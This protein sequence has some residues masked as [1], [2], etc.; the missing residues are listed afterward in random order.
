MGFE[1]RIA[2]IMRNTGPARFFVPLGIILIVFGIIVM[3]FNTDDYTL[4]MGTIT[5]V[6]ESVTQEGQKEYDVRFTY[7]ADGKTYEGTFA[8]LPGDFSVGNGIKVYYDPQD[9][10]K[11]T[12]SKLGFLPPI[13]IALGAAATVFGVWKTVQAFKKSIALDQ[14][15]GG[16]TVTE[17]QKALFKTAPG[18]KEMYFRFDGNSLRPGYL[19][20]DADKNVL[21]EGK[22]LKNALVGS[23]SYEFVDH[24]S[25]RSETHEVGHTVTQTFDNEF[26]SARSW[27]KIDGENV[28]DLLHDRGLRMNTDLHSRFPSPIYDVTKAGEMYARIESTSRYVHEEDEKAHR[29][30]VPTGRMY[31]RFW[32]ASDDLETMFITMFALSETEQAVAE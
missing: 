14:A 26:F 25:G 9:P 15:A 13:M 22:M 5:A 10:E 8:G 6:T 27:F 32:T 28:W 7:D 2:R 12:N 24:V 16:K 30:A 18:V 3:G 19:I 21:F 17:E 23:R 1:N 29:L 31:Y 20:E 4:T 11:I